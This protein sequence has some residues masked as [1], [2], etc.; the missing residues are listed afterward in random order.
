MTIDEL[1]LDTEDRMTKSVESSKNEMAKIRTGRAS[2]NMLDSIMVDYYGTATP[3][4][5]MANIAIPEPREVTISPWD[6]SQL[7]I[8]EKAILASDLGMTPSND[9]SLIRLRVPELTEERRNDLVKV[10]H[11]YGE[12]GKIAIRNIRRD[13]ND[14]IKKLQK[15][16][17]MSEDE[18]KIYLEEVQELT[19]KYTSQVDEV[20]KAKEKD[21]MEI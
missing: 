20:V 4:K 3:I 7:G 15:D 19:N 21:L 13:A 14:H 17:D 5:Q 16:G 12:E 8:I 10:V 9:G 6:R 18:E 2:A 11:K 1:L